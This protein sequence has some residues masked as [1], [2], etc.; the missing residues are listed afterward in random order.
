MWCRR[1]GQLATFGGGI[2]V[3]RFGLAVGFSV[4]LL[5]LCVL[6]ISAETW[7]DEW[8]NTWGCMFHEDLLIVTFV[9]IPLVSR[10]KVFLLMDFNQ[11]S[12]I[13]AAPCT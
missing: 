9:K 7:L 5:H 1:I 3:R 13:F 11:T 6:S 2:Q 12:A 10:Y 4:Q 8:L